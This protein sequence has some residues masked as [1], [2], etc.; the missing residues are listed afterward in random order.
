MMDYCAFDTASLLSN[1]QDC[2]FTFIF[3]QN[4]KGEGG[5][6]GGG[7]KE[8]LCVLHCLRFQNLSV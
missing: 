1:L 8:E 5:G 7:G 3:Q 2:T 4:M 6:R